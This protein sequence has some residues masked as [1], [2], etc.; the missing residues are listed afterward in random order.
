M[1]IA[2]TIYRAMLKKNKRVAVTRNNYAQEQLE[3]SVAAAENVPG[4]RTAMKESQ[5]QERNYEVSSEKHKR[6]EDSLLNIEKPFV[7]DNFI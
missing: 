6:Q 5:K 7:Q 4:L 2:D 3:K 1:K